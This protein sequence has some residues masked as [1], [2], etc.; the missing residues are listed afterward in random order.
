MQD[1]LIAAHFVWTSKSVLDVLW[2]T[3]ENQSISTK[4]VLAL[5]D[6][7]I[8]VKLI[9]NVFNFL[10]PFSMPYFMPHMFILFNLYWMH[11]R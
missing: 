4:I 6:T 1:A 10:I 2:D 7:M 8:Q 9:V 11:L 3:T 5:M